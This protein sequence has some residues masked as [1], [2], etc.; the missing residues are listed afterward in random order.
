MTAK[1]IYAAVIAMVL[2]IALVA[3]NCGEKVN[4]VRIVPV[5]ETRITYTNDIKPILDNNCIR[6][7]S[8]EKQ[9]AERNGAPP[10]VNLDKYETVVDVAERANAKIQSGTMPPTGGLPEEER[11]LFQQWLDQGLEE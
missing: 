6:C 10:D 4:P 1:R 9:G 11:N 2:F 5:T 3:L 7:H 8:S